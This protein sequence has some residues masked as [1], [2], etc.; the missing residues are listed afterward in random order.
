MKLNVCIVEDEINIAL[1]LQSILVRNFPYLNVKGIFDNPEIIKDDILNNEYDLVFMDIEINN[2]NGINFIRSLPP[3]Q[4][5]FVILTA[6]SNYT[7]EALKA[8][9]LTYLLKPVTINDLSKC[10]SLY[11]EIILKQIKPSNQANLNINNELVEINLNNLIYIDKTIEN[12]EIIYLKHN[13]KI[14]ISKDIAI[15]NNFQ[16]NYI[17][18]LDNKYFVNVLNIIDYNHEEQYFNLEDKLKLKM[19][20]HLLNNKQS[21]LYNKLF[22]HMF[23]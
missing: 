10:I 7:I 5:M 3:T 20:K 21:T 6:Y 23:D 2:I 4:T 22:H 8:G 15:E 9:A 18:N 13:R 17:L 19:N 1:G 14:I 16:S 11:Y 12:S